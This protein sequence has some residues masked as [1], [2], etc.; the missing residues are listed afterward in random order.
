MKTSVDLIDLL[1][2]ILKIKRLVIKL[3]K[4][5]VTVD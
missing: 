2:K 4:F 5:T 1:I 3:V